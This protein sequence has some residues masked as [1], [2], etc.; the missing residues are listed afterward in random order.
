M[1]N[2]KE[3]ERQNFNI[4]PEQEAQLDWLK[5]ALGAPSTK[6][7]VLRAV[8]VTVALKNS[9]QPGYELFL[10]T[11]QGP[12]RLLIPDLEPNPGVH[13]QYLVEHAHP[14]RKQLYVKGRKLRAFTVWR[15]MIANKLSLEEAAEN[16]DLPLDAIS[17]IVQYCESHQDLLNMEADEERLRLEEKGVSLEPNASAR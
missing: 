4:T 15:D 7:A 8:S 16:F 11:P 9:L 2:A 10:H 12:V 5:E 14:W 1:V 6:E 17:E 3:T 13:W